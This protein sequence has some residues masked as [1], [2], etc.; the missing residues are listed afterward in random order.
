M[1]HLVVLAFDDA[2][3]AEKVREALRQQQKQGLVSLDDAAIVSR[4]AEGKLSV[5]NE[6]SRATM[7][8]TGIGAL[9]GLLLGGFFFPLTGLALGALGGA[10]V[11][12]LTG[13]GVDG[14]FVKDV[15]ESLK[16]NS[17]ALFLIV[18]DA[19]ETAVLA[20][21]RNYQGRVLQTTLDSAT[22]ENLRR[23]LGD[24]GEGA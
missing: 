12:A 5:K 17:S 20:L 21:L 3:E 24:D 22:E 13:L 10:G 18:R 2:G 23:A 16:P 7:V 1:S 19:D 6:V 14:K 11:G 15:K 9:L 4:D 8:G